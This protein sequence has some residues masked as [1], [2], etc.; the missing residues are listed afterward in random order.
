MV[1]MDSEAARGLTEFRAA[2]GSADST[3]PE[4]R[5]VPRSPVAGRATGVV[6]D[7]ADPAGPKRICALELLNLSSRGF[8]ALSGAPLPVG[9]RIVLCFPPL[10]P[11]AGVDLRGTIVRCCERGDGYEVGVALSTPKRAA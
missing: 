11:L 10:G 3:F 2:A 9:G 8:G 5:A 7:S 6:S 1:I 4:R